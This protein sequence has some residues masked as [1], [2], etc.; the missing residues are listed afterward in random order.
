MFWVASKSSTVVRQSMICFYVYVEFRQVWKSRFSELIVTRR[1]WWIAAIFLDLP[2][3]RSSFRGSNPRRMRRIAMVK[4]LRSNL[5]QIR[6]C[7]VSTRSGI[8]CHFWKSLILLPK[9]VDNSLRK[10]A[11]MARCTPAF[12]LKFLRTLRS[13]IVVLFVWVYSRRP[14]AD[15]FLSSPNWAWKINALAAAAQVC[16]ACFW[17]AL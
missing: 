3:W 11:A 10:K 6:I 2:S 12:V 4:R 5:L 16:K 17:A 8:A 9:P 1:R 7:S 14:A 15:F 13:F